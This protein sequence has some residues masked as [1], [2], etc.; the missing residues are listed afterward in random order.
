MMPAWIHN[1]AEHLLAKNPSMNKSMAFAIATQQ[2]H[3]LG[4][5]PKGFGTKKGKQEAKAKYD[6]PKKE[7]VKT[8]NPG[9]LES[10]KLASVDPYWFM[11]EEL[12]K[13]GEG[14]QVDEGKRNLKSGLLGASLLSSGY[15]TNRN[16]R[17]LIG[18][19]G[20]DFR[21][22]RVAES[23]LPGASDVYARLK[24]LSPVPV[25]ESTNPF[26][27]NAMFTS[28]SMDIEELLGK[29]KNPGT[30]EAIRGMVERTPG[31]SAQGAARAAGL[32]VTKPYIAVGPGFHSPSVLSHE[33]GHAGLNRGIGKLLQ[34]NAT[35]LMGNV[36]RPLAPV[37]GLGTALASDDPRVQ[38]AGALSGAAL[39]IPQ[40]GFEAGAS[41][42]GMRH[43]REAGATPEH[44]SR[45][46]RGLR[47]AFGTYGANSLRILSLGAL[48]TGAGLVGKSLYR[49]V[50]R[51]KKEFG[52]AA[53]AP[54][55]KPLTDFDPAKQLKQTQD[56]GMVG[57]F[58]PKDGM[59]LQR[60]KPMSLI[61]DAA[62][63]AFTESQYSG[64]TTEW[65]PLRYRNPQFQ[66]SL[67]GAKFAGPEP[68]MDEGDP[69]HFP[70]K[71]EKRASV[72]K[73][74]H[75]ACSAVAAWEEKNRH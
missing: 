8:P 11:L 58:E 17:E 3:K 34:N 55:M 65:R 53:S 12:E 21:R 23:Q 22:H 39:T 26:F 62:K 47:S 10:P 20:S 56:V 24:K 66:S 50:K 40:L 52:K 28:G 29:L 9:G 13:V 71:E 25:A 38:A 7:Y 45:A 43:L 16:A 48:G 64:G 68:G 63:L 15:G 2:G 35:S 61:K 33:M 54:S 42:K 41:M 30:A 72:W 14:T 67:P 74:A 44:I 6:K 51:E 27:S 49:T 73:A 37:I 19:L 70:P 59:K 75:F 60:Y 32:D 69:E 4:K 5:T 57:A 46:A 1:R 31:Y 36:A 18:D